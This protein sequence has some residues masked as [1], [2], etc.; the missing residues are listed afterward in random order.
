M[1]SQ[2]LIHR[3]SKESS[4]CMCDFHFFEIRIVESLTGASSL[5]VHYRLSTSLLCNSLRIFGENTGGLMIW[6]GKG[7]F[8]GNR[9]A[10]PDIYQNRKDLN[11]IHLSM[12]HMRRHRSKWVSCD[13]T[14]YVNT[15]N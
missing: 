6:K 2:G 4:C 12:S 10:N 8:I 13:T 7:I 11:Y 5:S 1:R 9:V 3:R 15:C 14:T